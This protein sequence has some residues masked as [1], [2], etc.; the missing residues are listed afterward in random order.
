MDIAGTGGWQVGLG[1]IK[2]NKIEA[3]Y[4]LWKQGSLTQ[5]VL[6]H[7]CFR[8][9]LATWSLCKSCFPKWSVWL[10]NAALGIWE[11]LW[12]L[13]ELIRLPWLF[14][15]VKLSFSVLSFLK[16]VNQPSAGSRPALD[17]PRPLFTC[18]WLNCALSISFL[19]CICLAGVVAVPSNLKPCGIAAVS[20]QTGKRMLS[21]CRSLRFGACQLG[22]MPGP[23][24]KL[25]HPSLGCD[26]S[27]M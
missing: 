6:G 19:L 9:L 21:G 12:G 1:I 4:V 25:Q 2:R 11:L 15:M 8:K 5:L 13:C 24:R 16:L 17:L 26:L 10:A 7:C 18:W 20:V 23:T 27:W 14:G 22:W 3:W